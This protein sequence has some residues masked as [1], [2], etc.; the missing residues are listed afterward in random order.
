MQVRLDAVTMADSPLLT[1]VNTFD[2]ATR[3]SL[4]CV[5]VLDVMGS[6]RSLAPPAPV[7]SC[8]YALRR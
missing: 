3:C 7:A 4:P 6:N 5:V 1:S 8:T 2:Q